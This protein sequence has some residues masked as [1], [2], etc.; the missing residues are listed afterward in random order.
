MA[1]IVKVEQSCPP[2]AGPERTLCNR[3]ESE[4]PAPG[5]RLTP[6]DSSVTN[7]SRSNCPPPSGSIHPPPPPNPWKIHNP[8][9]TK[10]NESVSQSR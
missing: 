6:N 4:G 7:P 3:E 1:R 9:Y 2:G 10:F 8:F 5:G